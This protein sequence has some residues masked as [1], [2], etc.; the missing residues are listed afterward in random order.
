MKR[1]SLSLLEG[2]S[3]RWSRYGARQFSSVI[4]AKAGIQYSAAPPGLLGRP[5]SRAMTRMFESIGPRSAWSMAG[6]AIFV[7][8]VFPDAAHGGEETIE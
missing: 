5:P 8:I 2:V 7:I 4:P 6:V 3:T 1:D